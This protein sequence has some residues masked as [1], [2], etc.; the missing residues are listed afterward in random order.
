[1]KEWAGLRAGQ[2][3]IRELNSENT[4]TNLANGVTSMI[5]RYFF[6]EELESICSLFGMTFCQFH[7]STTR[8]DLIWLAVIQSGKLHDERM[9]SLCAGSASQGNQSC[10]QFETSC[11]TKF[12]QVALL[13]L[14]AH[15]LMKTSACTAKF[16]KRV[17]P[18]SLVLCFDLCFH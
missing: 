16:L 3:Q 8:R 17:P 11:S 5:T 2:L 13:A 14:P 12:L 7:S 18:T 1:M 4:M 15:R 9:G 10:S 6:L